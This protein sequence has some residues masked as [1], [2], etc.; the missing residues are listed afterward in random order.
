M[1]YCWSRTSAGLIVEGVREASWFAFFFSTGSLCEFAHHLERLPGPFP[2]SEFY[3]HWLWPLLLLRKH[4][5]LL[6]QGVERCECYGYTVH[7]GTALFLLLYR[8]RQ[9]RQTTAP[10]TRVVF[11]LAT[12]AAVRTRVRLFLQRWV[13]FQT[14]SFLSSSSYAITNAHEEHNATHHIFV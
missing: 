12:F 6:Q 4:R 5:C 1:R 10:E 11:T 3:S 14:H 2:F 7:T 13:W 9:I 8:T